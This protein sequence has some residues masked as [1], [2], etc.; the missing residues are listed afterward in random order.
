MADVA[1]DVQQPLVTTNN[2]EAIA[3]P[4]DAPHEEHPNGQFGNGKPGNGKSVAPTEPP[5]D[6]STDGGTKL[7]RRIGVLQGCSIILGIVIG[8]GIFISPVG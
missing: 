3:N 5:V 4:S 8:S 1:S 2:D 6:G 7:K